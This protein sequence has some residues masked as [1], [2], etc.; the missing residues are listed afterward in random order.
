MDGP[1]E[2]L[3]PADI[4]NLQKTVGNS[5]VMR[6]LNGRVT[7]NVQ[8]FDPSVHQS[9]TERETA[10]ETG[11]AFDPETARRLFQEG[12]EQFDQGEYSQALHLFQNSLEYGP[13]RPSVLFNI[14]DTLEEMG[15]SAAAIPYIVR[16]LAQP[17]ADI[18]EGQA[19]LARARRQAGLPAE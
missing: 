6:W 7:A 11:V 18:A 5:V 17:G 2:A 15:Q 19:A 10:G 3:R 4:L 12:V 9:T 1:P 16:Y 13:D 8:R 14:A